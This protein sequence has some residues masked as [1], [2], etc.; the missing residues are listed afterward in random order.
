MTCWTAAFVRARECTDSLPVTG[1]CG[2]GPARPARCAGFDG[3]EPG[4]IAMINGSSCFEI[5]TS[6]RR[7][8]F[9]VAFKVWGLNF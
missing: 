3:S 6:D 5:A 8:Y 7:R 4:E 9:R 2:G 1:V